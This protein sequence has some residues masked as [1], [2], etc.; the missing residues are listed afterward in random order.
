MGDTINILADSLD[1]LAEAIESTNSNGHT[2]IEKHGWNQPAINAKELQSLVLE[3]RRKVDEC[4]NSINENVDNEVIQ[5][6][7]RRF[8]LIRQ[9]SIPQI[10]SNP[11][12]IILSIQTT[13]GYYTTIMIP[14]Y[15]W[16]ID[17]G[18]YLPTK[19][20]NRLRSIQADIN[21]IA[22]KKERLKEQILL[23]SEATESAENIPTSLQ[24]LREAQEEIKKI[25]K[26]CVELLAEVTE[27]TNQVEKKHETVCNCE[28]KTNAIV[29]KCEEAYMITTTKGLAAAFDQR[30]TELMRSMRWWVGGLVCSLATAVIIGKN[31]FD[32]LQPILDAPNPSW[33]TV[34]MHVILSIIG[35]GAPIWL[36]WL[37]TK[38]IGQRF[39][40]AEDYAFKASTAKAYEGYRKEAVNLDKDFYSR[41]FNAALT[42]LEEAP[43]RLIET[44]V[45]GSPMQEFIDSKGF[46]NLL[47]KGS[48]FTNSIKASID[49]ASSSL[50]NFTKKPKDGSE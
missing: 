48:E 18:K 50:E 39:K 31:R 6:A 11:V 7:A 27:K 49:K 10:N 25:N 5:E 34:W 17:D 16:E 9:Q 38:Q 20:R 36:A 8:D 29:E 35:V 45:H 15:P 19:I 44:A 30:A 46:K 33:G 22:P 43:L 24:D 2:F 37:S 14:Q 21:D 13:I 28:E 32:T 40:V 26:R 42:R 3:F 23:I 1:E 41:L 47:D 4:Q 12:P